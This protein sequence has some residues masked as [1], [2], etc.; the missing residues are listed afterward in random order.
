MVEDVAALLRHLDIEQ[1]D[2]FGYSLG[3][4]VALKLA[5]RY[6]ALVR[7]LVLVSANYNSGGVHPELLAGM[8]DLEPDMLFG[9]LFHDEYL[10]T[11]PN[12]DAFPALVAKVKD[13]DHHVPE[14]P[15]E[16]IQSI[17]APTLLITGDSDIIRPEHAVEMF[18]LLG[19][20]IGDLAGLPNSQLAILPGT[21]HIT[22]VHRADLLLSIIPLFLDAPIPEPTV[23]D[24]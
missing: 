9:S 3:S 18:R 21:T 24:L 4:D 11:A 17:K 16:A 14:L 6:P 19:G 10:Q 15:A 22:V 20:V 8:D 5:I 7:K 1:A 12:P 13:M 2:L 23:S